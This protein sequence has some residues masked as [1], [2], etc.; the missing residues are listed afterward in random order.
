MIAKFV[1]IYILMRI[2]KVSA[3]PAKLDFSY[4]SS[5]TFF[6]TRFSGISVGLVVMMKRA[7]NPEWVS[8]IRS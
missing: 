4:C 8:I 6:L 3:T 1:S 2:A 5:A 7:V